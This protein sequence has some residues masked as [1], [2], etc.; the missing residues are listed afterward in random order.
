[1]A[2]RHVPAEAEHVDVGARV[3]GPAGGLAPFAALA[4]LQLPE[5]AVAGG[6]EH[7]AP[8]DKARPDAAYHAVRAV[9]LGRDGVEVPG[10]G[11]LR[12]VRVER[13]LGVGEREAV[14]RGADV[15]AA[16]RGRV[17]ARKAVAGTRGRGKLHGRYLKL[18]YE[19]AVLRTWEGQEALA[20]LVVVLLVVVGATFWDLGL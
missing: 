2:D 14:A 17:P 10:I 18:G 20:V 1:M 15:I 6:A 8:A 12:P 11:Q 13:V 4:P 7:L 19:V 5:V 3:Y 16:R 9:A